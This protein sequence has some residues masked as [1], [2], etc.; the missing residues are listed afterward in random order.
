MG[1]FFGGNFIDQTLEARHFYG[2]F[3]SSVLLNAHLLLSGQNGGKGQ[4]VKE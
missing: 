3:S 2:Q 1:V 4:K